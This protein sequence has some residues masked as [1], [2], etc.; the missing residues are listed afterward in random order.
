MKKLFRVSMII[1]HSVLHDLMMLADGN[2]VKGSLDIQPVRHGGA[3]E[4]GELQRAPTTREFISQYIS[5]RGQIDLAGA[6]AEAKRFGITKQA[7]YAAVQTLVKENVLKRDDRGVY[8]LKTSTR[9]KKA[10]ASA[11]AKKKKAAG[12]AVRNGGVG[13]SEHIVRIVRAK[14]TNGSSGGVSLQTI[15]DNVTKFDIVPT[16]VGPAL[17]KLV[18]TKELIRVGTGLYLTPD[19]AATHKAAEAAAVAAG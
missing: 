10:A 19:A 8:G 6:T 17:T 5:E 2:A 11:P 4:R 13:V 3:D 9:A 1:D 15:K 7:I 12:K 16:G 14:Q 18:Q